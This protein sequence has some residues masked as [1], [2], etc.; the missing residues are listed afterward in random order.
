MGFAT[1]FGTGFFSGLSDTLDKQ[2]A[3]RT[4]MAEYKKQLALQ[5]PYDIRKEQ[6]HR[7]TLEKLERIKQG[8]KAAKDHQYFSNG[9]LIPP[10][11]ARGLPVHGKDEVGSYLTYL[12]RL[13]LQL[14]LYPDMDVTSAKANITKS[15]KWMHW[16]QMTEKRGEY[17]IPS[18]GYSRIANHP[19]LGP[20]I[21]EALKDPGALAAVRGTEDKALIDVKQME[22][23]KFMA[24]LINKDA[25]TVFSK[26]EKKYGDNLPKMLDV[27]TQFSERYP[28]IWKRTTPQRL[29][30]QQRE[31]VNATRKDEY[32]KVVANQDRI[33]D[34]VATLNALN[35]K[36]YAAVP[37]STI[38]GMFKFAKR[39]V[40][41][42]LGMLDKARSGK[43]GAGDILKFKEGL[44]NNAF[45]PYDRNP[46]GPSFID[47]LFEG[48]E[49]LSMQD[50][51]GIALAYELASSWNNNNRISDADFKKAYQTVFGTGRES[52][53]FNLRSISERAMVARMEAKV[54]MG[55]TVP[56]ARRFLDHIQGDR[57][58]A[59][60]NAREKELRAR[61]AALAS[62]TVATGKAYGEDAD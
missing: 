50:T 28:D 35:K 31:Y 14:E 56:L 46:D 32:T 53:E 19:V 37:N 26:V 25:H 45:R 48:V 18:L 49:H 54:N 27:L 57:S 16:E 34:L 21:I 51:I 12:D 2:Q 52:T 5:E 15:P 55:M 58:T 29:S 42:L 59:F 44:T 23:G 36:S 24:T 22:D 41:S 43:M 1:A 17:V 6:R 3:S 39:E 40:T 13:D 47:S 4:K 9:Q 7:D 30:K 38:V 62:K 8:A 60:F 61:G 33:L 10:E 20:H 11:R